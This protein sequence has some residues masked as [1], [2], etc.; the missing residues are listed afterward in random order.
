MKP[1]CNECST[2]ADDSQSGNEIL[3]YCWTCEKHYCGDCLPGTESRIEVECSVCTT[4][5]CER[6]R[7]MGE[8]DNCGN[9]A[10]SIPRGVACLHTCSIPRGVACL[11]TCHDCNRNLCENCES[12]GGHCIG[13]RDDGRGYCDNNICGNCVDD[14]NMCQFCRELKIE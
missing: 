12:L 9:V 4:K 14:N 2:D 8:C 7:K 5:I 3:N 1:F 10:C 13:P 6:C 11:H